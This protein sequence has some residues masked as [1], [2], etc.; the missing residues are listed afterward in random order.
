MREFVDE[1]SLGVE[2]NILVADMKMRIAVG[3]GSALVVKDGEII[4][5][6]RDYR[7]DETY[8]PIWTVADAEKEAVKAPNHDWRIVIESAL[9]DGEYQRQGIGK[10]VL[11]KEGEGFA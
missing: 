1:D 11:V 6:E 5:H 7:H 8:N 4:Y 10:W 3:F 9:W 2:T